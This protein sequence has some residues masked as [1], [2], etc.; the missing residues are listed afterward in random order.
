[1]TTTA[2]LLDWLEARVDGAGAGDLL[3]LA[4]GLTQEDAYR[5]QFALMERLAGRG[6]RVIG[7]KAA[8]TSAAMQRAFS[9]T[10][11]LLGTL[12][13]S[14]YFD[15]GALIRIKREERTIVEP[16]IAALM[17]RDLAGP[18]VT[19]AEVHRALAG[20]FPALE[21]APPLP[22]GRD[23][24]RQMTTAL[25]KCTGGIVV[26]AVCSAV[27]GVDLRR[28]GSV[29]RC[30]GRVC[31]SGTGVEV[32]G[33]PLKVVAFVANKL[34]QFGRTLKA[35]MIVMTGSVVTASPAAPGDEMTA[36]FTRLGSVRAR[37]AA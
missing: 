25:H 2:D 30:N 18:G 12:L 36:E 17:G 22:G 27:A 29:L 26:G 21:I 35:G 4:P 1:M 37:F 24:S 10:E 19:V 8:F 28:E 13:G 33:N 3:H 6:D 14:G 34:A 32:L 23:C 15:S 16:E 7:Y 11:P 9:T 31:G 20:V 5:L